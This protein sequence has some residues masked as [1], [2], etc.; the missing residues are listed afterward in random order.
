MSFQGDVAGIGLGE[1]LQGLSR[2][3]QDGVLSLY[4]DKISACI[5]LH[6]GQLYLLDGP[7]EV[8][9]TW[10]E[11]CQQAF[12][13]D[14]F[15]EK[16]HVRRSAIARAARQETIFEMLGAPNLHF[17]FEPGPLPMPPG[18]RAETGGSGAIS[19]DGHSAA[20]SNSAWGAGI[21]VE[22]M[23]LEYAR[24]SDE[25]SSGPA[26]HIDCHDMPRSLDATREALPDVRDFLEQCDGS[27]TVQEIAD[28]LGRPQIEVAN[29]IG[30]HIQAENLRMASPREIL[31]AAQYELENGRLGRASERLTGWILCSPPGAPAMADVELLVREWDCGRLAQ[32]FKSLDPQIARSLLRKLDHVHVDKLASRERWQALLEANRGDEITCLHEVVL[33]LV[34]TEAPDARTFHDLLRLARSFQER[35]LTRRTQT[36]L[37]LTSNHMPT[38]PR[39]RIELGRRMIE[40][41]L[42]Q[43]GTRWLLNTAN[44]LIEDKQPE[45]A[46]AP[47]QTVL[48]EDPDQEEAAELLA[49]AR[50]QMTKKKRR[51]MHSVIGVCVGVM[52]S[53][54]ALV[55]YNG[56]RKV[57]EWES[58][59]QVL[60]STPLQS[61]HE[62]REAFGENPPERIAELLK[63]LAGVLRSQE[64]QAAEAWQAQYDAAMEACSFGDP[65]LGLQRVFELP[66]APGI[67]TSAVSSHVQDLLGALVSKL[68]ESSLNCVC[69]EDATT[70][71]RN[72]ELRF[73]EVLRRIATAS[74]QESAPPEAT[75]FAF[76]VN[77]MINKI[78]KRRDE[79]AIARAKTASK[80]QAQ[81]HSILLATARAHAASGDLERALNAYDRLL[82]EDPSL[83]DVPELME[84]IADATAHAEGA[85]LAHELALTGD[86]AGAAEALRDV[87]E[88]PLEH[89]LP[90]T[91]NTRP[92]GARVVLANGEVHTS[93]FTIKSGVGE[94]IEFSISRLGFER[95]K[96]QM[97]AP[98]NLDIHLHKLAER[99]WDNKSSIEA[100]PIAS[101]S[102]HILADRHGKILRIDERGKTVWSQNLSTLSGIART[103]IFIPG[104]PGHLLV[105]S[106]EGQAWIV[107]ANTGQFQGPRQVNSPPVLGPVL[108][109]GGVSVSFADGRVG[110]WTN[111][112][113]PS[114]FENE[115]YADLEDDDL[116]SGSMAVLRRRVDQGQELTSPWNQWKVEV[117]DEE[118][119]ILNPEGIGFSVQRQGSWVY[120]AW[121]APKALLS[122]GRLWIS[123]AAGVRSYLPHEADLID[124]NSH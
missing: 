6:R 57:N 60:Q 26:A 108:T 45:S 111:S 28:R 119:R 29:L 25:A 41:G 40:N 110:V 79:G 50:S 72:D 9:E 101:G 117:H 70:N 22:Y 67:A 97:N 14:P 46:I 89:P 1:L 37:R 103:P 116:D 112:I 19:L 49:H 114:F 120:M 98:R 94:A 58:R 42:V 39:T 73:L 59:F 32:L 12:A 124:F 31:A 81:S 47:L 52:L 88:R 86:H 56:Y 82:E 68:E 17:R 123:D 2:G 16:E 102:D 96:L 44:A 38:L 30:A 55:Q 21:T 69:D 5:G 84:E 93:P 63:H 118:Y 36:L 106:E 23:L 4:G 80:Q 115:S 100:L 65:L 48:R 8:Q 3:G 76:H 104:I 35:G 75:S 78:E 74:T 53:M 83:R 121:E 51:K 11:R 71:D 122:K 77:E 99:R 27:S 10:R 7:D 66:K 34:G 87:C 20:D 90:F 91:V 54:V 85:R 15:P 95:R 105:I 43:E 13:L 113:E 24:I 64:A 33:R 18:H 61:I 107:N 62:L 92:Q 109:R